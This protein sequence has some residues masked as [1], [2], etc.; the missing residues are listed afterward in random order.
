MPAASQ[1]HEQAIDLSRVE[2]G[3]VAGDQQHAVVLAGERVA[4]ADQRGR[5]LPGLAAVAK[6]GHTRLTRLRLGRRVGG[7]DGRLLYA[8]HSVQRRENVGEH[9]LGQQLAGAAIEQGREPLLGGP[10]ALDR[11]DCDRPDHESRA[12]VAATRRGVGGT[13]GLVCEPG[14]VS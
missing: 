9:R 11:Q 6:H 5:G 4:N 2:Q 1:L 8:A 10:E 12:S 13:A 14:T 7:H 3:G